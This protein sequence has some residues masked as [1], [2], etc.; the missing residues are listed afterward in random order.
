MKEFCERYLDFQKDFIL[1]FT[2]LILC[3]QCN[4]IFIQ[5][6]TERKEIQIAMDSIASGQLNSSKART[7][8]DTIDKF[9]SLSI[10]NIVSLPQVVA[11][12]S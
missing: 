1:V 11:I 6:E 2:F 8:L 5:K 4:Q 7:M 10:G 12:G 9:M 3:Q